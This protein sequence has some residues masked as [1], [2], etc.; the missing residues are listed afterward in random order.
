[1]K[2][3]IRDLCLTSGDG[4]SPWR[5]GSWLGGA[6]GGS[7]GGAVGGSMEGA[8]EGTMERGMGGAV[9]EAMGGAMGGAGRICGI[10]VS[11]STSSSP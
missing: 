3:M 1:M 2:L 6:V 7:M 4:G 9:E 8:V 5:S 10:V 11:T